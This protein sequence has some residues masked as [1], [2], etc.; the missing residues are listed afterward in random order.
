MITAM[1]N[2]LKKR[3]CAIEH[4]WRYNFPSMPN[5]AICTR[6]NAKAEL[7][8]RTLDWEPVEKFSFKDDTR[9]DNDLIK[10]WFR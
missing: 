6:C 5:R 2:W 8:L 1:R 7:N 10:A 9:T 3:K 4:D